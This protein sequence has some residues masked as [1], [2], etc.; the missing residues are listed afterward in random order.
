MVTLAGNP[1]KIEGSFPKVGDK[2]T[3][4]FACEQGFEGRYAGRFCGE[5]KSSEYCSQPG[6]SSLRHLYPQIQ[7][8]SQQHGQYGGTDNRG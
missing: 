7:R 4:F 5:E 3:R 6:Y 2:C 8:E 1:I